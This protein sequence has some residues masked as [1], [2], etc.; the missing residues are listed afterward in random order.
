MSSLKCFQSP[1][2][3]FQDGWHTDEHMGRCDLVPSSAQK[4]KHPHLGAQIHSQIHEGGGGNRGQ[5]PHICLPPPPPPPL[6]LNV[7]TEMHN[8]SD[9]EY[10]GAPSNS[11]LSD[12]LKHCFRLSGVPL[13]LCSFI[14]GHALIFLS[15]RS[16]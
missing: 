16:F 9:T 5:M 14:S 3:H 11:F 6:G 7:D 10:T 4:N 1:H 15:V 13:K 12:P 8:E 2:R